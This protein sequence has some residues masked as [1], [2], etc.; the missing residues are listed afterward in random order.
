MFS[1]NAVK[2]L[3]SFSSKILIMTLIDTVYSNIRS[4]I[5]GKK[6]SS[7]MLAYYN[8]GSQIPTIITSNFLDSINSVMFPMLSRCQD[9]V[10]LFKAAMRRSFRLYFFLSFP[11]MFGLIAVA[12]PLTI[13]LLTEKWSE[14]IP[15]MQMVCIIGMFNPFFIRVHA[16]NA[17]GRSDVSL[18][19]SFADKI[20]I[21]IV[22]LISL[23]FGVYI[24]IASQAVSNLISAIIGLFINK[25]VLKYSISEQLSDFSSTF[26]L[27]LIMFLVI[28]SVQ[29]LN[30]GNWLTMILQIIIGV[31]VYFLGAR[32]FKMDSLPFL[33]DT[34]K[35]Y[36][37]KLRG[38][39]A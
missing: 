6:Y 32:L 36:I 17:I 35:N 9:N 28:W 30:L 20:V 18:I 33:R 27:G 21:T 5:V 26:M 3:F 25:K 24:L 31:T 7:E 39:R 19:L 2:G 12:K 38:K 34:M 14:S 37:N 23:P 1:I 4:F 16:Y 11:L 22:L 15:F 10:Q 29:Y 8:R 13:I